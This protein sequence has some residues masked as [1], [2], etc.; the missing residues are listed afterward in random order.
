MARQV[1]DLRSVLQWLHGETRQRVLILGISIGATLALQAVEHEPDRVKAVVAVSP[2][3][4]TALSDAAA[5]TFLRKQA[6]A[7]NGR[8]RRR[9]AALAPPPYTDADSF[10]RRVRLLSD[11]G[12]IEYGRTF[13]ALVR[14][15]LIALV[16][17]YG[18][19]GAVRALRN[20]NVVTRRLLPEIATLDLLAHPPRVTVP[21]HYVF[22]ELDAL[23]PASVA[24]DLPAAIGA[25]SSTVARLPRA[26][27]ML[28][29]DQPDAVRSIAVRA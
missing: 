2:D 8:M 24:I 12:T 9:V 1:D 16:R 29:F 15:L 23:T 5:D 14:E 28:H 6:L 25:P 3:A 26:G 4:R 27:H 11:L 17:T 21:V 22:G 19:L 18:V 10:Q 7:G 20:M 13:S